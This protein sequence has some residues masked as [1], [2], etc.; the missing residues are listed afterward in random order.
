MVG[1]SGKEKQKIGF[2]RDER[3]GYVRHNFKFAMREEFYRK[4]V[5]ICTT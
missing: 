5:N 4:G 2:E 3:R 1:S